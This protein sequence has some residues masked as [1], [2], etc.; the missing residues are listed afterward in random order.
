MRNLP[1]LSSVVGLIIGG[2]SV[3]ATA[4]A[5]GPPP[6]V[7]S[8]TVTE[9]LAHVRD[10]PVPNSS[11]NT[12][13]RWAYATTL[14]T[15]TSCKMAS[16]LKG[17]K[18]TV[19][20]KSVDYAGSYSYPSDKLI[21]KVCESIARKGIKPICTHATFWSEGVT[22]EPQYPLDYLQVYAETPLKVK[23]VLHCYLNE[24]QLH[25]QPYVGEL[26]TVWLEKPKLRELNTNLGPK[27]LNLGTVQ[28]TAAYAKGLG[29]GAYSE[30]RIAL[31]V[32]KNK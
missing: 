27:M 29:E 26:T 16:P 2:L 25:S 1:I 9:I 4:G 18:D 13:N 12:F 3:H 11:A 6:L 7:S 19:L 20:N 8:Q 22:R 31:V 17:M 5:V 14:F 15:A 21:T 32:P 10:M 24:D 28:I 23:G 30:P